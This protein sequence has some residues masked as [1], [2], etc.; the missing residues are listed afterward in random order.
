MKLFRKWE[1]EQSSSGVEVEGEIA[2][3]AAGDHRDQL[4]DQVA[5]DL[6]ERSSAHLILSAA[7]AIRDRVCAGL[8]EQLLVGRRFVVGVGTL[9]RGEEADADYFGQFAAQVFGPAKEIAL[10]RIGAAESPCEQLLIARVGEE[11]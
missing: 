11:F 5:I 9:A 4:V 8:R 2:V 1:R 3:R 7:R 6:E 10:V